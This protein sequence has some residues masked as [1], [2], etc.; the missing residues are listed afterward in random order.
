MRAIRNAIRT[1]APPPHVL[2]RLRDEGL[3]LAP[4]RTGT[5]M[6]RALPGRVGLL[7]HAKGALPRRPVDAV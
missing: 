6:K 5:P 7:R 1:W 4:P 2:V 3:C